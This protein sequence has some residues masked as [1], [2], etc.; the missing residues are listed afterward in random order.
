VSRTGETTAVALGID[1]GGT[2]A[3]WRLT[4]SGRL[5]AQGDA[6]AFNGHIFSPTARAAAFASLGTLADAV[7]AHGRP[8]A[9]V[10]GITGLDAGTPEA[11]LYAEE[12]A[13]AFDLPLARVA[14]HNDMRIAYEA[15][16]GG[17]DRGVLVYSGTGS[18]GSYVDA[19]G[20]IV[21][22]GGRGVILDDGGSGFWIGKEAL[23]AVFRAEDRAT[24]SGFDT[25]LGRHLAIAIGGA[26]WSSARAF[27]YG[28]DRGRVGQLAT[29]VAA[30]AMDGDAVAKSILS[31]AGRELALLACAL[32]ERVGRRDVVLA[33]GASTVHPA[34]ADAFRRTLPSGISVLQSRLNPVEA[35]SAMAARLAAG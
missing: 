7:L 11:R 9:V 17:P 6:A 33:G 32:I 24:G 10:A 16:F 29:A 23:K 2:A 18:I 12:I 20:E 34:V 14:I 27:V 13:R 30:A 15:A 22:V 31:E 1:A 4:R 21:R 3:R 26:T 8:S 28:G 25:P 35:A 5:V 19:D